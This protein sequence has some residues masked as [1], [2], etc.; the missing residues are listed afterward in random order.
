MGLH[1]YLPDVNFDGGGAA[2]LHVYLPDVDS[3]GGSDGGSGS[4]SLGSRHQ[5]EFQLIFCLLIA[6]LGVKAALIPLHGWLPQAMVAPAPVSALLHAVAVVK[7]GAF[8][9]VRVVY[10]VYGIDL[11]QAMGLMI[12]LAILAAATI[13]YGSLRALFQNDLKKRLAFSTISQVSYIALG[14]AVGGP[15]STIGGVAHLVHQGLMKITMF[16]C[17]GNLAETLGIHKISEMRG[18]GRRM[19][20]T[21]AAFTVA[22]FGMIGVPPMAGFISKWYLGAG[23]IEA[24]Q[25]WV[26]IVLMASTALNAAYF[27]PILHIAWFGEPRG[28]WLRRKLT[29]GI[30]SEEASFESSSPAESLA[31]KGSVEANWGLLIPPLATASLAVVTGLFA[32]APIS[33]LQWAALVVDRAYGRAVSPPGGVESPAVLTLE[34][35]LLLAAIVTPLALAC[36]L[37]SRR[38]R[39]PV[40]WLAAFAAVHALALAC[41]GDVGTAIDLPWVLLHLHLGLDATGQS[42]LLFTSLLWL[43]A[44]IYAH[45]YLADY[46]RSHHFFG[47]FLL[48][49]AG[50]FGLVLSLDMVSFYFSFAVMS[51]SAYGLIVHPRDTEAFRAGRVYVVLVVLGEILLFA[52]MVLATTA[53]GGLRFDQGVDALASSPMQP[54]IFALLLVGLGIKAGVL[55]LH[56]WL[57]LAHPA[58]PI[59]ASAVLSGAMIKAGLLG[60]LRFLPVG[61]A[62]FPG[63]GEGLLIVG[64]VTAVYAAAVG[65]TQ[66]N[67]KSVLAYSSISQMGL[68]TLGVGA[69][70]LLPAAW[71]A[72][73]A[74]ILVYV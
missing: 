67:A 65:I 44:G 26:L 21:M 73:T 68:M 15:S 30:S 28:E 31:Q 13:L 24:S 23:A 18:V 29:P 52:G 49:M 51:V 6:G 33:P 32:G 62:A 64:S 39:R 63:W 56:V 8:G 41:F 40:L 10:D 9:I 19:P 72:I 22:A 27:L 50:N 36:C 2:W 74:A 5:L 55:P 42:F 46:P 69:G 14:V 1:S 16:F 48:T 17:A 71:P 66:S 37:F 34:G 20:W 58:A 7:A 38:Y 11:C 60:W 25:H 43:C 61:E 54:W 53:R 70:L 4:Q 47:F 3:N 35:I 59:P 45:G 12:P 57:P